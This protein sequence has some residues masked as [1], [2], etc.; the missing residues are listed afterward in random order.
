MGRT[1]PNILDNIYPYKELFNYKAQKVRGQRADP[2]LIFFDMSPA[3]VQTGTATRR[4]ARTH[5]NTSTHTRAHTHIQTQT[6]THTQS[7]NAVIINIQYKHYKQ[8]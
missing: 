3:T 8:L 1:K 5:T 7:A 4:H 2:L 6:H